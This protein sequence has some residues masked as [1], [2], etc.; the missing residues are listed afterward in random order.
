MNGRTAT[1]LLLAASALAGGCT[2]Q[3][4]HFERIYT[5]PDKSVIYVYRPYNYAGSLI[6]P[7][8]T[9]GDETAQ[10]APGAYHAFIVPAGSVTCTAATHTT[11]EVEVPPQS[12][13]Y[14]IKE[15]IGWGLL[16]GNPHLEPMDTDAAQTE[17]R[18]CCVEQP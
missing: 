14:Y 7:A 9:C 2:A 10:I 6:R 13:I 12:R 1:M 3:G 11:D 4:S 17:I 15:E 16:I 5:P 8:V 18:K